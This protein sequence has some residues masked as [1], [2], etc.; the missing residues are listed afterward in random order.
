MPILEHQQMT[1]TLTFIINII[2][3]VLFGFLSLRLAYIIRNQ[4]PKRVYN[5]LSEIFIFQGLSSW[6][7]VGSLY[8]LPIPIL[9][10]PY[11]FIFPAV[12]MLGLLRYEQAFV[13]REICTTLEAYQNNLNR[14]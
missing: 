6:L 7:I 13:R 5:R 12:F 2:A 11:G 9:N 1:F 4:Y 8:F 14:K 3:F 10:V